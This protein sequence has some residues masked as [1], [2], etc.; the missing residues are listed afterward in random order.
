[1]FR[2][3]IFFLWRKQNIHDLLITSTVIYI[4]TYSA[5][6]PKFYGRQRV[7]AFQPYPLKVPKIPAGE[8]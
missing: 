3:K 7:K 5:F 2:D 4:N 6:R 8:C 1:C